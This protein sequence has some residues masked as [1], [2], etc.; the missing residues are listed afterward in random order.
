MN[1]LD[2]AELSLKHWASM[3]PDT[4]AKPPTV[5]I[6]FRTDDRPVY[7]N[8]LSVVASVH[9]DVRAIASSSF[10]LPILVLRE[11]DIERIEIGVAQ[12]SS[13]IGF[14]SRK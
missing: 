3:Q 2:A 5:A 7:L 9:D 8:G 4:D 11:S 6:H 12:A 13:P 14:V 10:A 1:I